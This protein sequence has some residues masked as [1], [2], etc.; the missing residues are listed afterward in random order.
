MRYMSVWFMWC[1]PKKSNLKAFESFVKL[2][3]LCTVNVLP[4]FWQVAIKS[5]ISFQARVLLQ[6]SVVSTAFLCTY[7]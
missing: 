4:L 2:R 5:G 3:V 7:P 1:E 6:P